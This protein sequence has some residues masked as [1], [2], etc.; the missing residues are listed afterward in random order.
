M[1]S[2]SV[3]IPLYN[4]GA[5]IK[6]T[7]QAF[8]NQLRE[9]DEILVIDDASTDESLKSLE[10]FRSDRIRLLKL[11]NN[12]GPATARN[13][14]AAV[15]NGKFLLF[16]DADD[17]PHE[18]LLSTLRTIINHYPDDGVF[19]FNLAIA[20]RGE[21]L[22]LNADTE[23]I[24]SE[25]VVLER[26]AYAK[27]CLNGRHVCTASSTCVRND[28]FHSFGGFNEELRA[29]EDPDLW[30]RI[31]AH[32]RIVYLNRTL[33]LYRDVPGSLSHTMR[34]E[35]GALQPYVQTLL[36]LSGSNGGIYHR[37]ARSTIMKNAVFCLALTDQKQ[38]LRTYL[39]TVRTPLGH[40][41][42]YSLI[43][44]SYFPSKL[45]RSVLIIREWR[46]KRRRQVS[47]QSSDAH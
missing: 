4:K 35:P 18:N 28:V 20:A 26:H 39:R 1:T 23:L 44:L 15:A 16:F 17:H 13:R 30:V 46:R 22:R 40:F 34:S 11:E 43:S 45:L 21:A 29:G 33:A 10:V 14:G 47:R 41:Y 25:P 3:I 27:S 42:Y 24:E 7:V 8:S 36:S 37:L 38:K 2:I 12:S 9:D 31:S 19:C 6:A 5:F 32:H